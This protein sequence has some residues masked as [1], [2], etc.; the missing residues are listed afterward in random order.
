MQLHKK[1]I[2]NV[3]INM[4]LLLNT[5]PIFYY[6][7]HVLFYFLSIWLE[8]PVSVPDLTHFV[9][10]FPFLV[11]LSNILQYLPRNSGKHGNK[12]WDIGTE[13]AKP[14]NIFSYK[15]TIIALKWCDFQ[16]ASSFI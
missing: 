5:K 14:I 7:F 10:V 6:Y 8:T 13:Q 9:P 2:W 11:K 4:S 12:W 16:N 1:R 15:A 3:P